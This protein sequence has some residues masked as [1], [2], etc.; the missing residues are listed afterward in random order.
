VSAGSRRGPTAI[1][2]GGVLLITG[3]PGIGKTTLLRS[4]AAALTGRRVAGFTTDEI[5]EA[6]RRL[7]FRIVPFRGPARVMAHVDFR[8]PERVGRYGVDVAAIDAAAEMELAADPEVDV[9]L[10]DEIGKMECLSRRF[11]PAMRA[12]LDSDRRIVASIARGGGGFIAEVRHRPDVELWELTIR[13]RDTLADRVLEW[14]D[15]G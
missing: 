4:V 10:V 15:S 13:N 14:I 3:R 6:G 12:L 7:G 1:A 9:Y 8:G 11:A 2:S 5:R